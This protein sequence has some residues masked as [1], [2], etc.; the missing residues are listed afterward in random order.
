MNQ[1]G[2]KA[3]VE[4]HWAIMASK[5]MDFH[6]VDIF[7]GINFRVGKLECNCTTWQILVENFRWF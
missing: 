4:G 1:H 7:D 3:N 2:I 6:L 5:S